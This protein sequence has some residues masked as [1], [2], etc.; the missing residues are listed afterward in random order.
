[1]GGYAIAE[2]QDLA[3]A[4]DK[5][6]LSEEEHESEQAAIT[7]PSS[8]SSS[9]SS[10]AATTTTTTTTMDLEDE[11]DDEDY[12][13]DDGEDDGEGDGEGEKA[14]AKPL[15]E[16][17][18]EHLNVVFIGHVDAGK[19]TIS[20]NLLYLQGVVDERTIQKYEREA[21][22]KN[23]DSWY[24]AYIMD[25]NEEERAKVR[26]PSPPPLLPSPTSTIASCIADVSR[27][28]V[29][30]LRCHRARRSRSA[31]RTLRRP[32]SDTRSSMLRATRTTCPT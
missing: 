23:R 9:S 27:A 32:P 12:G 2:V 21:K 1:M 31:A 22:E 16:D 25:T 17:L 19:S 28:C 29:R 24:Y 20:G 14:A 18:R 7:E 5:A 3:D 6:S 26:A 30:V 4:V 10:A 11:G 15:V 13:D 8:S